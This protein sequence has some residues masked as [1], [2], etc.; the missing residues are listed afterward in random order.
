MEIFLISENGLVVGVGREE[1]DIPLA[2]PTN[3]TTQAAPRGGGYHDSPL[4]SLAEASSDRGVPKI[5]PTWR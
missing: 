2:R 5:V 1:V 3:E 4:L